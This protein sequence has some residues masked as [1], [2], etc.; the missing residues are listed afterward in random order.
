MLSCGPSKAPG[1]DGFNLKC[2][3]HVWPSVGEEFCMYVIQFFETGKLPQSINTTWV[4]L[5]PKKKDGVIRVND[6]RPISMVGSFY[7]VIAK[8]LSKR[9]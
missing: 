1:Y 3:K 9:L 2:I 7:K 6:F 4:T 8:I 5:I